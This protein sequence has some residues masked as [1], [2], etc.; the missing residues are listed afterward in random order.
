MK[1]FAVIVAALTVW[2][3][4]MTLKLR[5]TLTDA[6]ERIVADRERARVKPIATRLLEIRDALGQPHMAAPETYSDLIFAILKLSADSVGP[7]SE[8][9]N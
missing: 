6:V 8:K 9:R 5:V 1:I 7:F 4:Y 2:N 3:T